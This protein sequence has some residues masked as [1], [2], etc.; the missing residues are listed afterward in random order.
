ML[1]RILIFT[2]FFYIINTKSKCEPLNIYKTK[3]NMLIKTA[4]VNELLTK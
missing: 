3:L 2:F 4:E 1:C